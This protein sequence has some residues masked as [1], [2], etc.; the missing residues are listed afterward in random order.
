MWI[1]FTILF[2]QL[3]AQARPTYLIPVDLIG[4][5]RSS[6]GEVHDLYTLWKGTICHQLGHSMLT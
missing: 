2:V 4:D 5:G 3:S 1:I 6:F